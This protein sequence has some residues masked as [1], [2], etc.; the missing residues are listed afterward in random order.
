[1]SV[2][3]RLGGLRL[4]LTLPKRER[5]VDRQSLSLAPYDPLG[6]PLGRG[7]VRELHHSIPGIA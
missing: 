2:M 4:Q 6:S 5:T 1:M 7:P 3:V